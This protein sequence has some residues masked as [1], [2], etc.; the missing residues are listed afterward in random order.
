[1][2]DFKVVLQQLHAWLLEK[3]GQ[4]SHIC[5]ESG[6]CLDSLQIVDR[7]ESSVFAASDLT[8]F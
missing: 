3:I 8:H 7:R 4:L 6:L 1:M 5:L 2:V